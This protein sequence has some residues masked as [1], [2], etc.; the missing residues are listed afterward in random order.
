MDKNLRDRFEQI[1]ND[2]IQPVQ[3]QPQ[4]VE[5][6]SYQMPKKNEMHQQVEAAK[7]RVDI[8]KVFLIAIVVGALCFLL[9]KYTNCIPSYS[10]HILDFSNALQKQEEIEEPP[11]KK[12]TKKI[13]IEEEDS[14]P[15]FQE[16][17]S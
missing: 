11:T 5:N 9:L 2:D 17:D 12:L 4:L 16:F 3:S 7:S 10:D 8:T 14:D 13:D 6:R 1:L 15:L